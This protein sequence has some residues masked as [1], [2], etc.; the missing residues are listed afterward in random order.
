ME[1]KIS[2]SN[3]SKV[4]PTIILKAKVDKKG[5]TVYFYHTKFEDRKKKGL[6]VF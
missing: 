6:F 3:N 5:P 1:H 2:G 4:K